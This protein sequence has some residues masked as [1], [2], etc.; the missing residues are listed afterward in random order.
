V[1]STTRC[2]S[3]IEASTKF[4][5]FDFEDPLKLAGVL[6]EEEL[7]IQETAKQYA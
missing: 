2:F 7:M 1:P 3:T 6:T 5:K 4:D